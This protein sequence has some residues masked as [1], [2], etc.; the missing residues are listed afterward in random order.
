MY[1]ASNPV[2]K[3]AKG[4]STS[5]AMGKPSM[6]KHTLTL[7]HHISLLAALASVAINAL[8]GTVVI[9]AAADL[10]VVGPLIADFEQA[11][12][13]IKVVYHDLQ[14]TDL[15]D[16]FLDEIGNSSKADIVWSSAM[17][18]QMKLVNDGH[19]KP[20]RSAETSALPSW[21]KWRDEAF[22]TTFEP[23][24]FA[25]N[26]QL[27]APGAIPQTHAELVRVLQEQPERFRNRLV[28]YDPQRSGL[29]YLLHTQDLEANPVVFWNLI[30][31]MAQ[32]GLST[33]PTTTQMLDRI[34]SGQSVL[35]YNVLCSYTSSRASTDTRIGS[36]MPRDYTLVMSRIAFISRY[37]PHP[38][39]ARI[40]LDFML[41]KRGQAIFNQIGLHS[42]RTD[43]EDVASAETLRKQLG[44]AFRP[45]VLNTGLL[46]Y[47]DQSKRELFLN[48]WDTVLKA[49]RDIP[50]K[51][52]PTTSR[53][54]RRK[55]L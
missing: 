29:G 9:Y 24:C 22:G 17:D 21:A 23:V 50:A 39:E 53:P 26:R 28:T 43:V 13:E 7:L 4:Q 25:Y 2:F 48:Q 1:A 55:P 18:L 47:I 6:K 12:P 46:T 20:Y 15:N 14:S 35:G 40:W 19:A 44:N 41:S 38:D 45:I 8:A 31:V 42:V 36:V 51:D 30:Q 27:L 32:A 3:I 16:R 11:H 5:Q 37:A 33:E 49:G 52:S 10:Q 34:S 54:A